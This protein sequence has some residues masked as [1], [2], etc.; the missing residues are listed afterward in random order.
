MERPFDYG[1]LMCEGVHLR[2]G[3]VYK[4]LLVFPVA[5]YRNLKRSHKAAW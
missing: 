3:A 2:D 5:M 1:A 4:N